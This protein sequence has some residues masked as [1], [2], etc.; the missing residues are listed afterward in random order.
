MFLETSNPYD[1]KFIITGINGRGIETVYL[2][3]EPTEDK[4]LFKEE[5]KFTRTE[6]PREMK[7][8]AKDWREEIEY[9]KKPKRKTGR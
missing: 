6:M 3:E 2:P 7:K 1:F 5:Q 4:I 8:W 9:L